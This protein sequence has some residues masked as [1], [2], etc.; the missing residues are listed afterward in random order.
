MNKVEIF[1]K[2]L[3]DG[4]TDVT[5]EGELKGT[6]IGDLLLS[7]VYLLNKEGMDFEKIRSLLQEIVDLIEEHGLEEK[8][9]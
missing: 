8:T 1:F 4:S 2:N 3:D 7:L 5:I 9:S 6:E